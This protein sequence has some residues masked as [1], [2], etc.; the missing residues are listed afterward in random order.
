MKRIILF[1]CVIICACTCAYGQS[2]F[3]VDLNGAYYLGLHEHHS[4]LR[5]KK[6]NPY[7]FSYGLSLRYDLS[8]RWSAGVGMDI[9]HYLHSDHKTN[10]IYATVR[11]KALKRLPESYIFANVGYSVSTIDN[12]FD[13]GFTGS[14][15]VGYTKMFAKHF[16]LNFQLAY[17]LQGFD[18]N[19][20]YSSVPSLGSADPD[21]RHSISFG[22]GVTF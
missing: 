2:R 6:S 8:Q 9:A 5:I 22:V 3:H 18:N 1:F 11:Y 21:V 16:G 19:L 7:G 12:S 15:G 14:L 17:N 10:P 20:D 4:G 13:P